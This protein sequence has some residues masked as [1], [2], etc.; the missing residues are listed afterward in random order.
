[1]AKNIDSITS[2]LVHTT[3]SALGLCRHIT[4]TYLP[5]EY[6]RRIE[7]SFITKLTWC[8]FTTQNN[9]YKE[10][11]GIKMK[12]S[13][14]SHNWR[15]TQ[16]VLVVAKRKVS[17]CFLDVKYLNYNELVCHFH[18][19]LPSPTLL[20]SEISRTRLGLNELSACFCAGFHAV[21]YMWCAT[22]LHFRMHANLL[23]LCISAA[24][25]AR[26]FEPPCFLR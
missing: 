25:Q 13:S 6:S 16:P 9:N 14:S 24:L 7:Y 4:S 20:I 5:V 19:S 26:L 15:D 1:M 21:L 18:H 12:F 23:Q 2:A 3:A 8:S 11:N 17:K 22:Y 10:T